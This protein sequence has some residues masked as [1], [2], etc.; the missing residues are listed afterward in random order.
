MSIS[1]EICY[2]NQN[3]RYYKLVHVMNGIYS[4]Y[5][6]WR[7]KSECFTQKSRKR[8]RCLVSLILFNFKI[9]VGQR[10]ETEGNPIK[11]K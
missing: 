7:Q 9:E 10:E 3:E 2:Q 11:K 8:Y 4:Y 6:I 1:V 5:N